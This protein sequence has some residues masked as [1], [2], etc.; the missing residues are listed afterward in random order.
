MTPSI[1]APSAEAAPEEKDPDDEEYD[2]DDEYH[3]D[4]VEYWSKDD[5]DD[6]AF[7]EVKLVNWQKRVKE[8]VV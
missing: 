6:Q 7:T 1:S 2:Y 5:N 3:D 4:N 8:G